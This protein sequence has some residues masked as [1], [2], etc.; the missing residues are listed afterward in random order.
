MSTAEERELPPLAASWAAVF[1]IAWRASPAAAVGTVLGWFVTMIVAG[2]LL[3]IALQRIVADRDLAFDPVWVV[4]AAIGILA[5]EVLLSITDN[6][7]ESIRRRGEQLISTEIARAALRPAGIEHLE[8]P[9]YAD[10]VAFLRSEAGQIAMVFGAVGGQ[11][12]VVLSFI[13]SVAVL[14]SVSWWLLLPVAGS[15]AVGAVQMRAV[16]WAMNVREGMLTEQRLADHIVTL[17]T[18]AAAA[19]DIRMLGIGSWLRRRHD[20]AVT[21]VGTSLLRSERRSVLAAA[22]GGAVQALMLVAGLGLLMWLAIRGDASP[23]TVVL[24]VVLLQTV[25]ESARGLATSGSKVLRISFAAR[26]YLWLMRYATQVRPPQRPVPVPGRLDD[27]IRLENVSFRYPFAERD[28]L[29]NVSLTLPAGATVAIVGDNGAGKSTLVKLLCR[30]YD[31]THGRISVDGTDLREFD[32]DAWR[33]GITASFQDFARLEFRAVESIGVSRLD[34]LD[35][36]RTPAPQ[37]RK[38]I[39]EAARDGQAASFLEP[40]E[41]GYDTQLGRQFGGAQLSGGQW[42]RVAIA[43]T[44]ARS[45]PLLML[46]DEPTAALDA[47]AEHELFVQFAART[48]AA[49]ERGS[50]AVLVSHRFSTVRMADVV[51]VLADGA[52]AEVGTH[53]HLMAGDGLYRRAFEAQARHYH[54][55]RNGTREGDDA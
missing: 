12:G 23:A 20:R 36:Q 16:R 7:R 15:V 54:D 10:R 53:E 37:R 2:P 24:G 26:R 44:F 11:I 3:G 21:A 6:V 13:V 33:S 48:A 14:G 1:A 4:V 38:A 8:N 9:R 29:T 31:T 42:Q 39:A 30:Y 50:I 35:E 34:L 52:V 25:L 27:G 51:V 5:P 40:L 17:A 18:A 22:L 46:L 45:T 28:V 55:D 41:D 19:P 47:R 49:R 32:P 43:R